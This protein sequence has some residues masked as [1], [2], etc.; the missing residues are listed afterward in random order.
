MNNDRLYPPSEISATVK[1]I[2]YQENNATSEGFKSKQIHESLYDKANLMELVTKCNYLTKQQQ[3]QQL[4]HLL[5][6]YPTLFDRVLKLFVGPKIHLEL[7]DKL[8]PV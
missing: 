8:V 3:Q 7:V 6:A 2:H 4:Y 1:D 5:S